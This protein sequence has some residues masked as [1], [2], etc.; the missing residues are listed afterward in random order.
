MDK[1]PE[2]SRTPAGWRQKAS[3]KEKIQKDMDDL[4]WAK[5]TINKHKN[6]METDGTLNDN[7]IPLSIRNIVR[8]Y[9]SGCK[10]IHGSTLSFY[11]KLNSINRLRDQRDRLIDEYKKSQQS[12]TP[13]P[14]NTHRT[15][16]Q[17]GTN[18]DVD[19]RSSNRSSIKYDPD[20]FY[21]GSSNKHNSTDK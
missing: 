13:S 4:S 17:L 8:D 20:S 3:L 18:L 15:L 9:I 14:L 21:K 11:E 12:D 5:E 19:N 2:R 10:S 16:E 6:M 1:A 7:S